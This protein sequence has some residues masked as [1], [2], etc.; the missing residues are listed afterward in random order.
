MRRV[1]RGTNAATPLMA[2]R[3]LR[4]VKAS[5]TAVTSLALRTHSLGDEFVND[6]AAMG[7][8]NWSSGEIGDGEVRVDA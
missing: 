6:L 5:R 3:C 7:N 4:R 8:V 1:C 2:G